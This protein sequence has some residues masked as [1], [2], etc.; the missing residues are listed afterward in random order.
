MKS[1]IAGI[2]QVI[3]FNFTEIICK[4]LTWAKGSQKQMSI[5]LF[6][7]EVTISPYKMSLFVQSNTFIVVL[8]N[9]YIQRNR[10]PNSYNFVSQRSNKVFSGNESSDYRNIQLRKIPTLQKGK[11]AT[12]CMLNQRLKHPQSIHAFISLQYY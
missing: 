1:D 7:C 3:L 2:I 11:D 10:I 6:F 12:K 8:D 4:F 9:F 5:A